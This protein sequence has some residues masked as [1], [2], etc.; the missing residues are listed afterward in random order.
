MSM[1]V[2][3]LISMKTGFCP[4]VYSASTKTKGSFAVNFNWTW[5]ESQN[6]PAVNL[7][8]WNGRKD[9]HTAYLLH[10]ENKVEN[11][12]KGTNLTHVAKYY[13]QDWQKDPHNSQNCSSFGRC[14]IASFLGFFSAQLRVCVCKT[15]PPV[16][17]AWSFSGVAVICP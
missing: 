6:R 10:K 17:N 1:R 3:P 11:V 16:L 12:T 13:K 5:I 15:V 2:L 8:F 9:V 7:L 4:L 14:I